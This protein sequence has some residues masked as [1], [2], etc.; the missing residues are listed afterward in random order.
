MITVC[1]ATEGERS[2]DAKRMRFILRLG[3]L[4]FHLTRSELLALRKGIDVLLK[5]KEGGR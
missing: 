5:R 1:R 4:G 2:R 3:Q